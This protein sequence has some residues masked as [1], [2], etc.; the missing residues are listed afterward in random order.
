MLCPHCGTNL[1]DNAAFCTNC[2]NSIVAA[3]PMM[4]QAPIQI[5]PTGKNIRYRCHAC[6]NVAD[7][8]TDTACPK[9]GAPAL[10]GGYIKMYRMGSAYGVAMPFGIY[11]DNEP[12][13]YIGNKQTC[14]IRVPFGTHRVHIAAAANRRCEDV[15]VTIAPEHPLEA[16]KVYMKPGF[17]TNK[18]VV[19]SANPAEVPD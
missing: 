9:C 3:Q 18:F 16:V 17:W 2:G 15:M 13:G 8:Q 14:W 1:P 6:K 19:V 5:V 7:V 10:P 4:N 11:I 12:C